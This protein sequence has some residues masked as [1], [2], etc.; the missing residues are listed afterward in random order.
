MPLRPYREAL[1]DLYQTYNRRRFVAPDPVQFLYAYADSGDREVV[2]LIAACLSYGRVAQIL[3]SI[4][5]VL[6]PMGPRPARFLR[7]TG[8]SQLRRTFAGFRHRFTGGEDL[9]ALLAAV[10]RVLRRHG[11]LECCFAAGA[12]PQEETVL[13]ALGAFVD[14][15]RRFG[16]PRG[17]LLPHPGK[18]SACKRLNLFLRW[19]VRNDEVDPGG[20]SAIPPAALIVP[21]DV[22]MHRM[23]RALGATRRKAADG[24]TAVEVTAAFRAIQP[25][26]PV[27]Y[28]FALTRMG[29]HPDVDLSGFLN[30][31][32]SHGEKCSKR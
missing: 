9:V 6:E 2:A 31:S 10:R 3:R 13:P 20:W 5:R 11:T 12:R 27:R 14:E 16:G 29:I 28:D 19:M 24:R 18:G 22:H 15:V 8:P 17:H 23:A 25:D 1:E 21:L 32:R 26:D 7:D 30:R 4:G